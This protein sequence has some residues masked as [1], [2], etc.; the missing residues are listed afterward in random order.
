VTVFAIVID[1][2]LSDFII[3][4]LV[5]VSRTQTVRKAPQ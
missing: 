3:I 1:G 2:G 5:K 4:S